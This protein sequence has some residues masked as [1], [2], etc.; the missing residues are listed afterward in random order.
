MIL[1]S[2]KMIKS[3]PKKKQAKKTTLNNR[4]KNT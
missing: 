2:E 1:K 4:L 3:T